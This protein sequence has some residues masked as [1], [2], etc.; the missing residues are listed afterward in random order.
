MLIYGEKSGNRYGTREG[1][2]C[3]FS[4]SFKRRVLID[5]GSRHPG[6]GICTGITRHQPWSR[7]SSKCTAL[8]QRGGQSGWKLGEEWGTGCRGVTGNPDILFGSACRD[9]AYKGRAGHHCGGIELRSE[10][11]RSDLCF[12][13]LLL[14]SVLRNVCK[15]RKMEVG[16]QCWRILQQSR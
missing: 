9:F 11:I 7:E 8:E 2:S 3:Y 1:R 13:V 15:E 4:K 10:E 5:A 6:A 12:K 14:D 16:S